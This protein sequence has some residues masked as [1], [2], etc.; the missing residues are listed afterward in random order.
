[1]AYL[2]LRGLYIW[3]RRPMEWPSLEHHF[4]LREHLI[5]LL[6]RSSEI[7]AWIFQAFKHV[8]TSPSS[9]DREPKATRSGNAR[10]HGMRCV[11]G[12]SIA[13]IATQ[14]GNHSCNGSWTHCDSRFGFLLVPRQYFPA[15]ILLPILRNFTPLSSTYLKTPTKHKRFMTFMSGG[16]GEYLCFTIRYLTIFCVDKYFRHIHLP[17]AWLQRDPR[18]TRSMNDAAA[19][20]HS[21]QRLRCPLPSHILLHSRWSFGYSMAI[22]MILWPP[23]CT[24]LL[25]KF[26]L[27]VRLLCFAGD[28]LPPKCLIVYDGHHPP[29]LEESTELV[30]KESIARSI[31]PL[32]KSL[33]FGIWLS[34]TTWML[35][36]RLDGRRCLRLPGILQQL[37]PPSLLWILLSIITPLVQNYHGEHEIC[38]NV[39][40]LRSL[41]EH[42]IIMPILKGCEGCY[43]CLAL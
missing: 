14:V 12:G 33:S 43:V 35:I 24:R 13:Y 34:A 37:T 10:L 5:I 27:N 16:T 8:F 26:V 42:A 32:Y 29:T 36:L 31:Q 2:S 30:T 15:R 21:L 18:W 9:V 1:M 20:W 22:F 41:H 23:I 38:H 40:R 4:G 39:I 3:R 11:T 17:S 7:S 19:F 28:W 25:K 6:T